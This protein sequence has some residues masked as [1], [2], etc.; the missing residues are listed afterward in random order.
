M[1]RLVAVVAHGGPAFRDALTS[2]WADGDAVVPVDPRLPGPARRI[3][4]ASLRP[5]R[6]VDPADPDGDTTIDR[7]APDVENGDALVV[8]TSGTT[9]TPKGVVLTHAALAAQ[10]RAVHLRL[11]IDRGDRWLA[12]L[13]LA[14]IGGLGVVVRAVLDG[15]EVEVHGRFDAD[16][17]RAAR[18]AGATLTSLVPT[19]LDR[20]G[21]EGFR[22]VLLGGA[23]DP[24]PTRPGNVV[25]TWG[26]TE[27]GGGVVFVGSPLDGVE[28]AERDGELHVRAAGLARGYRSDDGGVEPLLGPG[29]GWWAS[30]D[31]GSVAPDGTVTVH[32]RLDDVIVTGGEKVW[33]TAV[34]AAIRRTVAVAEVA[35][36]G[37]PDRDW[38]ER[39]EAWVVPLDAGPAPT[40]DQLRA[41]VREELPAWCAPRAVHVVADLPRTA[42]GKVRRAELR[43]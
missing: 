3:L 18:D 34:E 12:C 19:A 39:V 31:G 16:A 14:H 9:A 10:A 21:A 22:W 17:V 4:L 32:G 5:T 11:G 28:V 20:V 30:G 26:A 40:L 33:P 27:T 6:L 13:P 37:R 24:A 2:V 1:P 29:D 35:V 15:V 25:R 36:A 7:R 23:A 38:G 42:S 8:P 41:G 43:A